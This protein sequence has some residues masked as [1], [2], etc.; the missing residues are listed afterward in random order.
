MKTKTIIVALI[1]LFCLTANSQALVMTLN[2]TVTD[3]VSGKVVPNAK[4]VWYMAGKTITVY[5]NAYGK[6]GPITYNPWCDSKTVVVS[7]T[8]FWTKWFQV[9]E[10]SCCSC[11][12]ECPPEYGNI[13]CR[14]TYTVNFKIVKKL[15]ASESMTPLAVKPEVA[16]LVSDRRAIIS[17]L[18]PLMLVNYC[19]GQASGC[20]YEC[21]YQ[22]V[23]DFFNGRELFLGYPTSPNPPELPE[24]PPDFA[25]LVNEIIYNIWEF[26]YG[27]NFPKKGNL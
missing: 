14:K 5:T 17:A 24:C 9:Y 16:Q 4:V 20:Q 7:K 26:F 8:G 19:S 2:G 23:A 15:T 1:A 13:G 18:I 6:Y 25:D 11:Y 21:V 3:S 12:P 10:G 22:A 27:D